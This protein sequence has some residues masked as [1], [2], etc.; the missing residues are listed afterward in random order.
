MKHKLPLRQQSGVVYQIQCSCGQ[1]YTGESEREVWTRV[2]EH[3]TDYTN[4]APAKAFSRHLEHTPDFDGFKLL[5]SEPRTDL[6]R[7]QEAIFIVQ[8]KGYVI[9]SQ[10]DW[11][12]N[13][14]LGADYSPVWTE[15]VERVM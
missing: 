1:R 9:E 3:Q 7:I 11:K 15:V 10:S 12:T 5:S 8:D 6:R 2:S 14:N 4:N 13:K